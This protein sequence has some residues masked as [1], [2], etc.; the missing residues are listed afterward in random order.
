MTTHSQHGIF[1]PRK[2]LNL[3]VVTTLSLVPHNAKEALSDPHWKVAMQEEYT[4]LIH[5]D[6]QE[7][8][9][10]PSRVNIIRCMW[11]FCHKTNS[12]RSFARYKARLVGDGSSQQVG[13]DCLETFTPVVKPTAI[14]VVLSLAL[15]RF[16]SIYQLDVKNAFLHGSL[17]KQCIC[18]NLRGFVIINIPIMCAD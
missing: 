9:P 6:T 3:S 16:W 7:L 14:R 10:R 5:N 8:V 13:V 18:I 17:P 11:I 12:D 1:K 15:S 2:P 4:A